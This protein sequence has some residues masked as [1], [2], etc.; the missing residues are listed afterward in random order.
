MNRELFGVF[1]GADAFGHHAAPSEFDR[2]LEGDVVTVGVRDDTGLPQGTDLHSDDTGLCVIWG[3]AYAPDDNPAR[4]LLDRYAA[5][6]R[7]ALSELNGSYLAVLE[8]DGDAIVATDLLR[9][10][11]CFYADTS[12]GRAFG[13]DPTRVAATQPS[14]TVDQRGVLQF[15]YLGVVLGGRTPI[16]ELGRVRMDAVLT[17]GSVEPL[18]RFVY[19]PREFDYA[20]ELA[21]RLE[22][23]IHRRAR[24]RGRTGIL[25]GAGYDSRAVLAVH[26]GV[27]ACYTVGDRTSS[28]VRVAER[29]ARQYGADHVRLEPDRRYLVP[30][31]AE[32]A[33]SQG[34]RETLH[35]HHAG[36]EDDMCVDEIFHGMLF[37]TL[38]RNHFLPGAGI[39]VGN[40]TV[41]LPW[42]DSDPDLLTAFQDSLGII[43][44]SVD[45]VKRCDA[46][47]ADD[48]VT[49]LRRTF[50]RELER[51]YDRCDRR[52][53]AFA[54]LGIRARPTMPFRTHLANQFRERF[55]AADPALVEWHLLTPPEHRTTETFLRAARSLDDGLLTHRP[56]DR[57]VDSP[58]LNEVASYL[59]RSLPFLDGQTSP[60]PDRRRLYDAYDL[61]RALLSDVP[62]LHDAPVQF[63][64]RVN[65]IRGWISRV[66]DRCA[67][68]ATA[69]PVRSAGLDG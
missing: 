42:L 18:D 69:D 44:P 38:F 51:C 12:H 59:G 10:R 45:L 29:L 24:S 30:S 17:G 22:R 19:D 39:E 43:V 27:D 31:S 8:H 15:L 20:S 64:L 21:G 50:D 57:P 48:S 14:P 1:G 58:V 56:P 11:E 7:P 55:V 54:Q 33:Y 62:E 46:V 60:W 34:L 41:P 67:A 61:D 4:W 9:T 40:L 6:G 23:A 35:I 49:F 63:K 13:S 28:E 65:D 32:I 52:L 26:P 16:R 66:G 47:D 53:N 68:D 37:D 25:L 36:H 3:E 5:A 2:V